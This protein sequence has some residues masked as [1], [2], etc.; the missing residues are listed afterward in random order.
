[1]K[2]LNFLRS[3][4]FGKKEQAPIAPVYTAELVVDESALE[5][6]VEVSDEA[7]EQIAE[8]AVAPKKK[9]YIKKKK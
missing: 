1:M 4:L 2:F 3:L 8:A 7:V 6:I 9:K 5:P